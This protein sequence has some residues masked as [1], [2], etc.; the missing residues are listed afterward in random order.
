MKEIRIFEDA[1]YRTLLPLVYMRPVS[2]LRCGILL[3]QEKVVRRYPKASITL[4]CR[5]YIA[6]LLKGRDSFGVNRLTVEKENTLFLNSRLLIG[7][8]IPLEGKEEIGVQDDTVVYARLSQENAKKVT[9]QVFLEERLLKTVKGVKVRKVKAKLVK[10]SWD[11]VQNNGN[12]IVRDFELLVGKKGSNHGKVYDG[13]YLLNPSQIYIGKGSKIKPCVVL[14]AEN[15]PIYIGENVTIFPNSVVEGPAYIG[16]ET[17][18]KINAKIYENTSI[19]PVCKI[20]GEVE[21]SILHAYSNKQHDGFLGHAYIGE[22]CNLGAG[23]SNSDL[24]NNYGN[25]KVWVDGRM[26][27]SGS[28]F[29]G[30]TMG[31]HSKTGVNTMLNTGTVVGVSSNVFGAGFPPKYIPSFS[32]GGASGLTTYKLEKGLEVAERVMSRRKVKLG[33]REEKLFRRIF[34]LTKE[35]RKTTV[36]AGD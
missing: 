9:P 25:V 6:D 21:G 32:W 27:D 2:A 11:L 8:V 12:E 20:G 7:E 24:K 1:S 15:G 26:V 30:L 23:T 31:D 3:L 17:K 18:L 28:M 35:E 22:W 5:D 36:G 4:F 13:T 14:D 29:V 16:D 10:Y 33:A 19:G 34:E